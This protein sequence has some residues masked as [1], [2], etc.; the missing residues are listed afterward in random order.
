MKRRTKTGSGRSR[1]Q[2]R[3]VAGVQERAREGTAP[4]AEAP[5]VATIPRTRSFE[6]LTGLRAEMMT[7]EFDTQ[8]VWKKLLDLIGILL[9]RESRAVVVAVDSHHWV[10][11]IGRVERGEKEA[12]EA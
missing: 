12:M 7:E 1:R 10:P 4:A 5:E 3:A 6:L 8:K 9:E 2:I 11:L